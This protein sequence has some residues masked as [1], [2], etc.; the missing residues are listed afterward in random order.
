MNPSD[1]PITSTVL[2]DFEA[3]DVFGA[4]SDLL[5]LHI[6]QFVLKNP[7][8]TQISICQ[9]LETTAG[10]ISHHSKILEE[11]GVLDRMKSGHVL[12][13]TVRVDKLLEIGKFI[14]WIVMNKEGRTAI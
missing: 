14:G 11:V 12:V 13:H 9:G 2:R 6:V 7:G 10:V 3:V 5:R 8:C 1:D 4:L